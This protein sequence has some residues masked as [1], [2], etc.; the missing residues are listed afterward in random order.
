LPASTADG[1]SVAIAPADPRRQQAKD[2]DE[3][4]CIHFDDP[5]GGGEPGWIRKAPI[6]CR[7]WNRSTRGSAAHK[8]SPSRI[9]HSSLENGR[10]GA[11]A[12]GVATAKATAGLLKKSVF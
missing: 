11:P 9:T 4:E 1:L 2:E 12:H 10:N 8:H 6:A 7:L 5:R 3:N